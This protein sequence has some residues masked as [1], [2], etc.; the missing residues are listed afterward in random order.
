MDSF[1]NLKNRKNSLKNWLLPIFTQ[2]PVAAVKKKYTMTTGMEN[3]KIMGSSV[4]SQ[5]AEESPL[6]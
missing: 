3:S 2:M 4:L 1:Q 5:G 6:I